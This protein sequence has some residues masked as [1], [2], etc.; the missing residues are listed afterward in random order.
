MFT[1]CITY[2]SIIISIAFNV[3]R[4]YTLYHTLLLVLWEIKGKSNKLFYYT[5]EK[6]R[7][8]EAQ[9]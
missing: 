5:Q 8:K 6:K 2:P 3:S 1:Y 9:K 4:K 7:R